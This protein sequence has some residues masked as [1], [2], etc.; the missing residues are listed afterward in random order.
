MAQN[1]RIYHR[2]VSALASLQSPM[3][4]AVRVY[5]GFQFAPDRWGK[6]HHLARSQASS[7][8][9]ISRFRPQRAVHCVLEFVGVFLMMVSLVS[10]SM[11]FVMVFGM[12]VADSPADREAFTSIFFDPGK[13]Y[14]ADPY[15]FLFAS[16]MILIFGAGL[17]SIDALISKRLQ[18]TE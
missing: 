12:F 17:F 5:W 13:F 2:A 4:L 8:A 1:L 15:T 16:L 14:V 7:P 10:W 6:L 3:M 9:S 18:V 11:G